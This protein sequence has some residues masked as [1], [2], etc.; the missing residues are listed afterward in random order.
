LLQQLVTAASAA[1]DQT[2]ITVALIAAGAAFVTALI[3]LLL[4]I[5]RL[6]READRQE[7]VGW[8]QQL[9]ELYGPV[10]L[11]RRESTYLYK[12]LKEG[13]PDPENWHVLDHVQ[14]VLGDEMD[15]ALIR[16]IMEI[17]GQ[18]RELILG[19]TGLIEGSQPPA[20]FVHFLGHYDTLSIALA[21]KD[22]GR[23]VKEFEYF[24]LDF[25][26]DIEIAYSKLSKLVE[27]RTLRLRTRLWRRLTG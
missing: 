1:K 26:K 18:V 17:N 14:D 8:R 19:K 5:Y 3:T 11:L 16:Q 22:L 6:R 27:E 25:D 13:K 23:R 12:K 21:K 24:P 10:L 9:S 7:L 15:A 2:E 4:E 20:S